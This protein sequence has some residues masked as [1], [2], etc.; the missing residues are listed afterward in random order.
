[1][2]Q[3]K[4]YTSKAW[5]KKRQAILKRDNYLCQRCKRYGKNVQATV[6]HH[7]EPLDEYPELRFDSKNLIS[8]CSACHNQAHPEKGDKAKRRFG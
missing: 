4:F 3:H 7:I 5:Q 1:M 6:V 2:E 8:L